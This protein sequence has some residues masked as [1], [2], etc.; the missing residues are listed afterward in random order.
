[1]Q[2]ATV[3]IGPN[4]CLNPT[5]KITTSSTMTGALVIHTHGN[6]TRE[7]FAAAQQ[8]VWWQLILSKRLPRFGAPRLAHSTGLASEWALVEIDGLYRIS[9]S[10]WEIGRDHLKSTVVIPSE[11]DPH[12]YLDQLDGVL[13]VSAVRRAA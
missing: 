8:V 2:L 12:T 11:A 10:V 5:L 1:M 13:V 3:K 4:K 6:A 7:D 9:L